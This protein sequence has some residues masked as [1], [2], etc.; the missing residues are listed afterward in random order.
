MPP[1]QR[2]SLQEVTAP[3]LVAVEA[4]FGSNWTDTWKELARSF[5]ITLLHID[6]PV[7]F[8]P[9]D[10][11]YTLIQGIGKDM[12]GTQ[13]YLPVSV[14]N[15]LAERSPTWLEMAAS[16]TNSLARAAMPKA[17]A[18][19]VA[20]QLVQGVAQ[21]LGGTQPYIPIG[22]AERS[23]QVLQL[24]ASG[25]TYKQAA[26]ACGITVSR[27][28]NIE[29]HARHARRHKAVAAVAGTSTAGQL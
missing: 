9:V 14:P 25:R 24:L 1:L 4:I 10:L 12:G 13:P 5:Y 17:L 3:E 26:D 21:D 18:A 11:A 19:E 2:P 22:M 6:L 16:F 15:A 28:R 7:D 8:L 20:E 27:V 29:R 23:T